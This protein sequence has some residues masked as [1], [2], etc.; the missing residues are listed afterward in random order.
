MGCLTLTGE[1]F[2]A[3]GR[4]PDADIAIGLLS[5]IIP[6]MF[7]VLSMRPDRPLGQ[8]LLVNLTTGVHGSLC[9]L[10]RRRG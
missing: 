9:R 8:W 3:H 6:V 1:V 10:D 2:Y 7:G 4:A 5:A